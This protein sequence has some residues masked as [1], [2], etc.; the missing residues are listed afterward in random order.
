MGP[1]YD[2]HSLMA[3]MCRGQ[4]C[5]V[6]VDLRVKLGRPFIVTWVMVA[7]GPSPIQLNFV[8]GSNNR[9]LIMPQKGSRV[10]TSKPFPHYSASLSLCNEFLFNGDWPSG[11]LLFHFSSK[12]SPISSNI[13]DS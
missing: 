7:W 10:F 3:L 11:W 9:L 13:Y 4:S 1:I 5:G 2:V 6:G 12:F 8:A